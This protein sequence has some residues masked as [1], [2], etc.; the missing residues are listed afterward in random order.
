MADIIMADDD[1]V[2]A[3]NR[4]LTLFKSAHFERDGSV[5]LNHRYGDDYDIELKVERKS[6]DEINTVR[7]SF[8]YSGVTLDNDQMSALEDYAREAAIA[9]WFEDE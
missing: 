6:N 4:V 5:K 1:F 9:L 3:R 7:A 2:E 8:G